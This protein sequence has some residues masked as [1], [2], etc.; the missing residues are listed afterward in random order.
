MSTDPKIDLSQQPALRTKL[1]DLRHEDPTTTEPKPDAK[2]TTP[3]VTAPE[4]EKPK[5]KDPAHDADLITPVVPAQGAA[6]VQTPAAPT[7]PKWPDLSEDH[8][9]SKFRQA[10]PDILTKSGYT[11]VYGIHLSADDS[12][13]TTVFHT[14]L[15][16]QKFLRANGNDLDKA[17]EQLL[18]TLKWR[19]SFQPHL[20]VNVTFDEEKFGGLGYIVRLTSQDTGDEVVT[21]NVYGAVKDFKKTFGDTEEF[22][23]WRVALMERS[24]AALHLT[25][26]TEPIPDYG[27]GEDPY[28]GIQVHDYQN[29]SFLRQDPHVKTASRKIIDL[30]SRVYPETMSKKIFANVPFYMAWMFNAMRFLPAQTYAK[31]EAVTDGKTLKKSL[32]GDAVDAQI[33]AAYGGSAASL[34]EVAEKP[35][36]EKEGS[37]LI[38]KISSAVMSEPVD[39]PP[40]HGGIAG[41]A[42]T[43]AADASSDTPS[44]VIASSPTAS[45]AIASSASAPPGPG[46][47]T[48]GATPTVIDAAASAQETEPATT[49]AEQAA[50]PQKA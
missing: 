38:M 20:L 47:T 18:D 14:N 7:E 46:A 49:L 11:E 19:K 28:C 17:K 31:L 23:R 50:P 40:V 48:D 45:P 42:G 22:I 26:A 12:S 21:F 41:L 27:L 30:F 9:I 39:G 6:P 3:N 16:L 4:A 34:E 33:P 13:A 2:T 1:E 44:P 25:S 35:K 32:G 15:I 37:D 43:P 29:V 24:I 8:P 10:L 5:V 36:L